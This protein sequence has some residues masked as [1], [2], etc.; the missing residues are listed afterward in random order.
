MVEARNVK[1]GMHTDQKGH[2]RKNAKLAQTRSGGGHVT[3][4]WNS[5]KLR[6]SGTI[7]ARNFKFGMQIYHQVR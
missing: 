1:F 4:F 7:R 5:G 6:I 3:Y 2:K